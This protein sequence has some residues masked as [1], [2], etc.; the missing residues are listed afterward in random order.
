VPLAVCVWG[1]VPLF[2]VF[3]FWEQVLLPVVCVWESVL[4][5]VVCV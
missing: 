3:W 5:P 4:L 1:R 2:A